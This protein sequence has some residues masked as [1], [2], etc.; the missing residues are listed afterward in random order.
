MLWHKRA[1]SAECKAI[2]IAVSAVT[3]GWKGH[4]TSVIRIYV[5]MVMVIGELIWI[6]NELWE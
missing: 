1:T 6:P 3:D 5:E 4:T 2:R